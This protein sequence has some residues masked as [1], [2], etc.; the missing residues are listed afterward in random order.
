MT[1]TAALHNHNQNSS[2]CNDQKPKG[3]VEDTNDL[4][5][6]DYTMPEP[7]NSEERRRRYTR[8]KKYEKSNMRVNP[9]F[10]GSEITLSNHWDIDI[11]PLPAAQSNL[12]VIG[13][14]NEAKA[15]L[16][17]D[18]MAVYS[19][20][21][22]HVDSIIKNDTTSPVSVGDSIIVERQGGRVRIPDGQIQQYRVAGQSMPRIGRK[23]VFFLKSNEQP[24]YF[25]I[26]T[27]YELRNGLVFPLDNVR[28]FKAYSGAEEPTFLIQV[29]NTIAC[30][31]QRP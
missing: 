16:S 5:I 13:E 15:Y 29:Q 19:E 17:P 4:P 8:G 1:A 3:Q 18:K 24:Q 20:F 9:D 6:A 28:L 25:Q 14:V 26:L 2:C 12:I 23:Y 27:G 31:S 22:V 11:P 21:T 7:A 10:G 30:T